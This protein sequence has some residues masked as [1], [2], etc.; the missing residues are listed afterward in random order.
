MHIL[1]LA[2]KDLIRDL[3]ISTWIEMC[4]ALGNN[5]HRVTLVTLSTSRKKFEMDI[6]GVVVKEIRAIDRFPL[7]ALSFH[8][9]LLW[10]ACYWLIK[11]S[12]DVVMCHPLTVPF[13]LPAKFLA[14]LLRRS[15]K[16]V[17]DLRTIPVRNQTISEKIKNAISDLAVWIALQLFHGITV[18]SYPLQQIFAQ[19]YRLAPDRIGVW[20]AG[21]NLDL[22]QPELYPPRSAA[23]QS[24]Q[25]IILYHGAIAHN[26]GLFE[27]VSAM[28][29]VNEKLPQARLVIIGQGLAYGKLAAW[30]DELNLGHCVQLRGKV[31]YQEIPE[32]IARADIGIVPLPDEL[33][34]QVSTPLKLFEYLAMA[35]PVL[36][37]PIDAHLAVV[38]D[39]PAAVFLQSTSPQHIAEGILTAYHRREQLAR[40]A[41]EN[42]QRAAEQFS[43]SH[44][45]KQ[46][47]NYVASL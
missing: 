11:T 31:D 40:Y 33:C 45:A 43:W 3:D 21:V 17:V 22:F 32:H 6:P 13:T 5:G 28:A 39:H 18:V 1:W 4:R 7:L 30:I 37:S 14:K 29:T 26:R 25:Y 12:P 34:W 46:L 15:C 2:Q 19:R 41:A 47:V 9:Q 8:I 35:K 38:K 27:T 16:F 36:V 42:R 24:S 44:R 23:I 10:L 20:M